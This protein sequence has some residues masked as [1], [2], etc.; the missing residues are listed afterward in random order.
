MN[1][2]R[3]G[4]LCSAFGVSL[5]QST[6]QLKAGCG[7]GVENQARAVTWGFGA[8]IRGD[9]Q[10]T[11][12]SRIPAHEQSGTG[13]WMRGSSRGTSNA[14]VCRGRGAAGAGAHAPGPQAVAGG[15]PHGAG[16]GGLHPHDAE[17]HRPQEPGHP[18]GHQVLL[19]TR[20][21]PGTPLPPSP[22]AESLGKLLLGS[23]SCFSQRHLTCLR[24]SGRR[25][26]SSEGHRQAPTNLSAT[27]RIFS[28]Q[29]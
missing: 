15:D 5:W 23:G 22:P 17:D 25:F 14:I 9:W 3:G 11:Q 10:G 4:D 20:P 29:M 18:P 19:H 7:D 26:L 13:P 2:W 24:T 6:G 12:F 21:P 28:V 1:Q 8:G 27:S 16:E